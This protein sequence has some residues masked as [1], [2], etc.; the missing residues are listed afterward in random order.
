MGAEHR[1]EPPNVYGGWGPA[2]T[3]R[4]CRGCCSRGD[5]GSLVVSDSGDREAKVAPGPVDLATRFAL[6]VKEAAAAFGISPEHL[7]NLLPEIPHV[8]LGTRVVI[9]VKPAEEWLC[10]RAKAEKAS[11]DSMAEEI[12]REFDKK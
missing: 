2:A 9:P 11:A 4:G 8:R 1:D 7:R 3:E 5:Q 6:S 10:E 12:L